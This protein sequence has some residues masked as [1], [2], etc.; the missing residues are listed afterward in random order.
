MDASTQSSSVT[1]PFGSN[2]PQKIGCWVAARSDI[3]AS[4]LLTA[5]LVLYWIHL[6]VTTWGL[7]SLTTGSLLTAG[8]LFL[9]GSGWRPNYAVRLGGLTALLGVTL[10][11]P[12]WWTGWDA[13]LASVI[14]SVGVWLACLLNGTLLAGLLLTLAWWNG[15]RETAIGANSLFWVGLAVGFW[16]TSAGLAPLMP[17]YWLAVAAT[18]GFAVQMMIPAAKSAESKQFAAWPRLRFRPIVSAMLL[19][20]C[21]PA[22]YRITSQLQPETT[23]VF[24]GVI[25]SF[26]LGLALSR[27]KRLSE[28]QL[29]VVAVAALMLACFPLWIR[30]YLAVSASISF[31]SLAIVVRQVGL[32]AFFAPFGLLAGCVCLPSGARSESKLFLQSWQ[33]SSVALLVGATVGWSQLTTVGPVILLAVCLFALAL[34]ACLQQESGFAW[35]QLT[36]PRRVVPVAVAAS[37]CVALFWSYQ[38]EFAARSLFSTHVFQAWRNGRSLNTVSGLDDGRLLSLRESSSGTLTLWRHQGSHCQLRLNGVPAG[39][40]SSN[41]TLVPQPAGGTLSAV[42]P[43]SLHPAPRQVLLLGLESGLGLKTTLEF[44]VMQVDCC[45]QNEALLREMQ[46]GVL[47]ETLASCWADDRVQLREGHPAI[48]VRQLDAKY[49][50]ILDTPGNSA[51]YRQ[52]DQFTASRYA[53]LANSL[54]EGGMYCQRFTFTDYGP[55]ALRSV[56]ETMQAAFGYVTAFDTAPGEMLFVA[57]RSRDDVITEKLIERVSAPQVRRSLARIGWDWSVAMNLAH[58]DQEALQD[59]K[60]YGQQSAWTSAGPF[61]LATEMMRW[62]N[63]WGEVRTALADKPQH[64]LEHYAE[65]KEMQDVLRRLSDVAAREQVLVK[66]T[67]QFWVY[68]KS[69]KKRLQD[70]PRTIIEPVKGEGLKKRIH[71]DDQRRLDYFETLGNATQQKACSLES[72]AAVEEYAHPYDPLVSYFM[73][74]EI[75]KLYQ[76]SAPP[77]PD[78]ELRHWLHALYFGSQQERSV[79]SIHRALELI[80]TAETEFTA[81]ERYDH[82]STLMELLKIRW[83]MRKGKQDLSQAVLLIDLKDSLR[84]CNL[85]LEAMPELGAEAGI[86]SE[87]T[88]VRIAELERSLTRMLQSHRAEMLAKASKPSYPLPPAAK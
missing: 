63:K 32:I 46:S 36:Q 64:L 54:A 48:T 30:Y 84:A 11:T 34:L 49:D 9:V 31:T 15:R 45:E 47:S 25:A 5:A 80:A 77:Q 78:L 12:W 69:V 13:S 27:W 29:M 2:I 10:S 43:L 56:A 82:A 41:A 68:R 87:Q 51:V 16:F 75:A 61:R 88:E 18:V 81:A 85:A 55:D 53:W 28:R 22:V 1:A 37:A 42:L 19:G 79:R 74:A 60:G 72:L 70:E 62:G 83:Q 24:F 52:A 58:F 50:V 35:K 21:L 66:H 65:E 6:Q 76:R 14:G 44:P 67:D 73:H 26:C 4:G 86:D 33:I 23:I 7:S 20:I 38:P 71:P 3:F 40:I 17:T 8:L 59:V 57:A 39:R